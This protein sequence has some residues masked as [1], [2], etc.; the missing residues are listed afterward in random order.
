MANPAA[1]D[2][3][4]SAASTPTTPIVLNHCANA[5]GQNNKASREEIAKMI[6]KLRHQVYGKIMPVKNPVACCGASSKEKAKWGGCLETTAYHSSPQ[7]AVGYSGF[8]P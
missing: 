3:S 6:I 7:Q 5:E 2:R 8:F 4:E 1:T